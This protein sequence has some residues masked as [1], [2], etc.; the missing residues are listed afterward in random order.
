MQILIRAVLG[1]IL[2]VVA[3]ILVLCLL[4][5][6]AMAI[7]PFSTKY[8]IF[9]HLT[10]QPVI[11]QFR[12]AFNSFTKKRYMIG[13]TGRKPLGSCLGMFLLAATGLVFTFI[14][15]AVFQASH[16][17]L[18][19]TPGTAP[20]LL[21]TT[22]MEVK[23]KYGS[24]GNVKYPV[25]G[26]AYLGPKSQENSNFP[27]SVLSTDLWSNNIAHSSQTDSEFYGNVSVTLSD[28]NWLSI[29]STGNVTTTVTMSLDGIT[30]EDLP[31][32]SP[33][34]ISV[35]V[36][37]G[38]SPVLFDIPAVSLS[39]GNSMQNT[40]A[41]AVAGL[42]TLDYVQFTLVKFDS[43]VWEDADNLD[44]YYQY[45]AEQDAF[46]SENGTSL[47]NY[48]YNYTSMD[49]YDNT[50]LQSDMQAG[51]DTS[52]RYSLIGLRNTTAK[53][54][55]FQSY[56][57]TKRSVYRESSVK[58]TNNTI[59][60]VEYHY[61]IQIDRYSDPTALQK[62]FK[63]KYTGGSHGSDGLAIPV[64]P[65]FTTS[66]MDFI[67]MASLTNNKGFYASYSPETYV[68]IFPLI[69]L[70]AVYVALILILS[71]LSL[72]WNIKRFANKSY[73]MTLESLNY[74]LYN[75][76]NALIPLFQKVRHAE[77]AMVDG[78]DPTTGYNHLGLV[79]P[80]DANRI[81]RAEPD[82]PYGV[83]YK[84]SSRSGMLEPENYR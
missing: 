59:N 31:S 15:T 60:L 55:I 1:Q 75:P 56:A 50:T 44:E 76:G 41:F 5:T 3:N 64:T 21:N 27:I 23:N 34:T 32:A 22:G 46:T 39:S 48:T 58:S 10:H 74:L 11:E 68:D 9:T 49:S 70:M 30:A 84:T 35:D 45:L 40:Y 2:T 54:D 42:Y 19:N 18:K 65:M 79:A 77:L 62:E 82:V 24:N 73:S 69:M 6:L 80:I 13:Q 83:I 25:I 29:N 61:Q 53:T 66:N 12:I 26:D 71:I 57:L 8:S 17:E 16:S 38:D 72:S 43:Q 28:T 52:V 7:S 4:S 78:Y 33:G 67:N 51:N 47:F 36:L 37:D 14:S 81:A 63:V 20:A